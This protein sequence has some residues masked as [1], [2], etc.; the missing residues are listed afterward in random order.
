MNKFDPQFIYVGLVLP[1][2]FAFTLVADGIH[3]LLRKEPA[4][5]SFLLAAIFLL[6]IISFYFFFLPWIL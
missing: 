2:L 5:I 1:T 4:W 6:V 3:K